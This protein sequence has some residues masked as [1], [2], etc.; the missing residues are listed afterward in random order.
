MMRFQIV[1]TQSIYQRLFAMDD[2][3][4]REALYAEQ[5]IRSGLA[6]SDLLPIDESIAIMHTLDDVRAQLGVTYPKDR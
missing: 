4:A 3:A 1:D 5:V 2:A 6:N